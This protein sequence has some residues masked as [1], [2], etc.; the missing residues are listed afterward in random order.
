MTRTV[1]PAVAI[2]LIGCVLYAG[3]GGSIEVPTD[4]ATG[5]A[6]G[7]SAAV[8]HGRL[9]LTRTLRGTVQ[10]RGA[11]NV[12][13]VSDGGQGLS[14]VTWLPDPGT[15]IE[16]GD[17]LATVNGR[18]VIAL[19]GPVAAYRP[20]VEGERGADVEALKASLVRLGLGG[21]TPDEELRRED[22][23]AV[24]DLYVAAGYEVRGATA[25]SRVEL[26]LAG[27]DRAVALA[28]VDRSAAEEEASHRSSLER[29]TAEERAADA[30]AADEFARLARAQ[31]DL[32]RDRQR[33]AA[34]EADLAP[35]GSA[36]PEPGQDRPAAPSGAAAELD[37]RENQ[38]D[39]SARELVRTV[40]RSRGEA[41]LA[42]SEA[43]AAHRA[44][45]A[46]QQA[47]RLEADEAFRRVQEQFERAATTVP[48]GELFF[49]PTLPATVESVLA[50]VGDAVDGPLLRLSGSGIEIES[51][52]TASDRGLLGDAVEGTVRCA[53]SPDVRARFVA[54]AAG[55]DAADGG[56][57][58]SPGSGSRTG[59]AGAGGPGERSGGEAASG[60]STGAT[61]VATGGTGE[62]D[63]QASRSVYVAELP[64]GTPGLV[65]GLECTVSV[66]RPLVE[67]AML[68]VPDAALREGPGATVWIE[69]VRGSRPRP[70]ATVGDGAER[71]EVDVRSSVD[72]TS[73]LVA[74]DGSSLE[75]VGA[76]RVGP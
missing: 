61:A 64:A 54:S 46:D 55:A 65:Q 33:L 50:E 12:G 70:G 11:T 35:A 13:F 1:V 59:D 21:V 43:E 44:R 48:L 72:G 62:D 68:L 36:N 27:R 56:V 26:D 57:D 75:W 29:I 66:S 38:L 20:L 8:E 53:G 6:T 39:A 10:A 16:E 67:G 4:R 41:R 28:A 45:L 15:T 2:G 63:P 3:S 74:R 32:A 17:V 34:A 30:E 51:R 42:R 37:E 47:A 73:A 31:A 23:R 52:V 24:A 69:A 7:R 5:P 71:V 49:V 25:E 40:E 14:T 18:P 22:L 19:M 58:G 76:V 60:G 9:E